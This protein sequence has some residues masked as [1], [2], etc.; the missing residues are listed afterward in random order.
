MLVF[1]FPSNR[2]I[3]DTTSVVSLYYCS[4]EY[5]LYDLLLYSCTLNYYVIIPQCYFKF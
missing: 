3:T 5:E 4:V 1:H 2:I